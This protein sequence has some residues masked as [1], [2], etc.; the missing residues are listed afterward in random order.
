[1]SG[2]SKWSTIKRQKGVADAK[3][4][5]AFTKLSN[6]I[7]LAIKQ[8]GG[9]ADPDSN[10]KLRLAIDRAR[11]MNMPKDNIERAIDRAKASSKDSFDEVVY[12]GFAPGGVAIIIEAATDNKNRTTSEVKNLIEKNGG[13]MG[14]PG[15]VSYMFARRGELVVKKNG[16]SADDILTAALDDGLEDIEEEAEVFFLYTSPENLMKV[17]TAIDTAGFEIENAELVY[18]PTTTIEV[19]E[20]SYQKIE[21]LMNKIDEHDDVQKIYSNVA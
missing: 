1:M 13:S 5:Q 2:H 18:K 3:R 4:G 20:A 9:I 6:A 17:K 15:S 19:D 14:N 11:T 8:G 16:I 7:T 21:D 12:E 10:F